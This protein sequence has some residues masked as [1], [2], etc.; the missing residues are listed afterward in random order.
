VFYYIPR[1]T[2]YFFSTTKDL[3]SNPYSVA[4]KIEADGRHFFDIGE[5]IGKHPH[6]IP[7]KLL[8]DGWSKMALFVPKPSTGG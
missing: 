7:M 8:N 1:E 6:P 2:T 3:G 4:Y 5:E